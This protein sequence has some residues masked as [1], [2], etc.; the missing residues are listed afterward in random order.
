VQKIDR[1]YI[2]IIRYAVQWV[3]FSLVLYSGVTFYL[4]VK[5]VE[6]GIPPTVTRPPSVEGFLPIGGFVALK[7]WITEGILD[8]IHPAAPMIFASAL[9]V[10]FLLRKSFCSWICP[11]GTLSEVV[12]MLG[13]KVVG[14]NFRVQKYADYVLRSLKYIIMCLFIYII[15]IKM[16]FSRIIGFMSTPYWKVADVKMLR[17][18]TD[19]SRTTA[20]VLGI[21][22][23]LSMIYKNVWCR[24]LCPYGALT[25]ILGGL[26]PVGIKRHE[27]A[28]INCSLCAKHCPSLLPVDKK[29]LINSP[30]CTGCLTCVSRCPAKDA[31]DVR[32]GG[33]WTMRPE[34]MAA[35]IVV[36][37][38]G[39]ITAARL[40]GKWHSSVSYEE[41]KSLLSV[42][43]NLE[44]P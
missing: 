41:L 16:S 11:V 19:I 5:A 33:K 4:Y 24:Y 22:V 34:I 15:F 28:C 25:G 23:V 7:L 8:P 37:F 10:S 20:I 18:F 27:N 35:F 42:L 1:S 6:S 17:F 29:G 21:L 14:V 36:I 2:R 12:W 26:G 40:S 38:F 30:E 44:H 43:Q 31:L 13:E 9:L 3:V 32:V 39:I